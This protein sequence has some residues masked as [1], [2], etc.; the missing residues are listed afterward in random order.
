MPLAISAFRTGE[1]R[2]INVFINEFR[3]GVKIEEV[4]EICSVFVFCLL[5]ACSIQ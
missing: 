5:V 1:R 4:S 2:E 3:V